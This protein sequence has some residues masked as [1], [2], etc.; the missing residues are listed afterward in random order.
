MRIVD[1]VS[2]TR[3]GEENLSQR[4][5]HGR[6]GLLLVLNLQ[7]HVRRWSITLVDM[8]TRTFIVSGR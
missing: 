2:R 8:R 7:M 6:H 4:L 1:L 5:F 3:I